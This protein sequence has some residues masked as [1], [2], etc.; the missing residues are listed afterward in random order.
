MG[1][2]LLNPSYKLQTDRIVQNRPANTG[3]VAWKHAPCAEQRIKLVGRLERSE[4]HRYPGHRCAP[5]KRRR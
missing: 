4:A 3:K 1:I 5:A 2:A